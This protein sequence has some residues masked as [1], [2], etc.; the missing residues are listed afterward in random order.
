[1]SDEVVLALDQG[2]TSSRTLAFDRNGKV[3]AQSQREFTQYFPQS[4]WVEHDGEEIWASQEATLRE[5]LEQLQADNRKVLAMGIT[6]Q[7]ET[8]LVW[9]RS[10]GEPL[11]R[12]IVW[13]DRRTAETCATLKAGGHEEMV[14]ERTGLR[15]DPYFS[16]TKVKWLLDEI[17]DA[18]ARAARGELCF[19]TMD[20]WLIW[21]LTGGQVHAT[22][23]TNASRTLLLNI[24]SGEWD[25]ELCELLEIPYQMLPEVRSCSEVYGTSM[26]GIP[27]AGV[28]GD[29]HAAL[30]GQA[31][32]EK[33][34]VKNTY[35]TGCFLVM[36]T[37]RS[38]VASQNGLLTTIGWEING[39]REYALEGSIFMGGALVQWLRDGLQMVKSAAECSQL[40]EE[41]EGNGGLYIVP[42]FTGLGAPHWDPFARGAAIGMSRGTNRSH[43]CR[44][45][46]EA[47]AFQSA[48]VVAAMVKDSGL[49]LPEVRVDGGASAS[50][51]LMQF[52]ADLL[53]CPVVR[54][55]VTETT[56]LGAA[57]L[58]GLAVGMWESQEEIARQW[59]VERTFQVTPACESAEL[60][61]QWSRAVARS[62]NWIES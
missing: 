6:N 16:G 57:Y 53:N 28:A 2:T 24:H 51:F 44:A 10:T 41:A 46:L 30:F 37:G 9:D 61:R 21:K 54:P 59:Q 33:G 36:N 23:I 29:Q 40:A 18:R 17:P 15:L 20:S 3:V 12:A 42:A 22:D 25:E 50:N 8:T 5:V 48:E 58:A 60:K 39:V 47:I 45:V 14:T 27:I 52:Q 43:F 4:G 13:Q 26:D 34:M 49:E 11:H 55:Q 19:G 32:F 35:G 62:K 31:C 1:M 7:R 56:A 38:A